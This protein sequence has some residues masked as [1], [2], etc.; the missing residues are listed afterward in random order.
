MITRNSFPSSN[1]NIS[2]Q[3]N[4]LH[5]DVLAT[6]LCH[7]KESESQGKHIN[8]ILGTKIVQNNKLSIFSSIC[9][10]LIHLVVPYQNFLS[11]RN[12][13]YR[14]RKYKLFLISLLNNTQ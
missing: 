1:T 7:K 11:Q 13:E 6:N 14:L 3:H 12:R 4:L 5:L 10:K 9:K 8:K 2:I